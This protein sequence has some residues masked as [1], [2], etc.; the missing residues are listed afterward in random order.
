MMSM[1][2]KLRL[3]KRGLALGA[4]VVALALVVAACGGDDDDDDAGSNGGGGEDRG[5]LSVGAKDFPSAQLVSQLYGQVLAADGYDVSYT[6][7]GP[8]ETTFP[9]LQE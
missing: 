8:T 2:R 6:D 9:A 1:H 4:M 5:S 7:L 3:R